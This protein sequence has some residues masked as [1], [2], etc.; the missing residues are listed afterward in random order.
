[1][2]SVQPRMASVHS[3]LFHLSYADHPDLHSFPTRRSSDLLARE[4][5]AGF[6]AYTAAD[7]SAARPNQLRN[8][9]TRLDRKSTRLNSSHVSPSYAVFCLKNK[10]DPALSEHGRWFVVADQR[11]RFHSRY[12]C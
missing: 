6:F 8:F 10:T 4:H 5:V 12:L 3:D 11:H 2:L 1:M 7:I 9:I